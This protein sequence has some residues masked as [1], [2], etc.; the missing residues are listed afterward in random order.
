M[1]FEDVKNALEDLF[2]GR[3]ETWRDLS[4]DDIHFESIHRFSV[5]ESVKNNEEMY[6]AMKCVKHLDA[7][8]LDVLGTGSGSGCASCPISITSFTF[9]SSSLNCC[10][11]GESHIK[12]SNAPKVISL[13]NEQTFC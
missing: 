1:T 13:K 5:G 6:E 7:E 10:A 4:A 11:K 12:L 9:S 2:D 8:A 3:A